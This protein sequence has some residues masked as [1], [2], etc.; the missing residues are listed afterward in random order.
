VDKKQLLVPPL[1]NPKVVVS[2]V[3]LTD[4]IKQPQIIDFFTRTMEPTL[5]T[6]EPGKPE[7]KPEVLKKIKEAN[8]KRENAIMEHKLRSEYESKI[9]ALQMRIQDLIKENIILKE[10][11]EYFEREGRKN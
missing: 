10:R 3:K 4:F 11:W 5:S 6:Y 9:K 1:L 8:D 7:H 2:P